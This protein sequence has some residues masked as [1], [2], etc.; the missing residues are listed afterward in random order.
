MGETIERGGAWIYESKKYIL[1]YIFHLFF[2]ILL[3][4]IA[5]VGIYFFI[6]MVSLHLVGLGTNAQ[7]RAGQLMYE[8]RSNV[9][10]LIVHLSLSLPPY[11]S[12][13]TQPKV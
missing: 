8:S 11:V 2:W 12:I 6:Q 3:A 1:V 13:H 5:P 4:G 10:N 7:V 9:A